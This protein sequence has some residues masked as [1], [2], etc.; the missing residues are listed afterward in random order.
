MYGRLEHGTNLQSHDVLSDPEVQPR[1]PGK[2]KFRAAS[3]KSDS[4]IADIELM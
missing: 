2:I 4:R 3:Q 1:P